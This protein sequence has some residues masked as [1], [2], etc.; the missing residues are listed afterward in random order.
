MTAVFWLFIIGVGAGLLILVLQLRQRWLA[1]KQAEEARAMQ[2]IAEA[3]RASARGTSG[4]GSKP[5]A[6]RKLP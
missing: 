4:Q 1:R 3:M 6:D 5:P 2:M